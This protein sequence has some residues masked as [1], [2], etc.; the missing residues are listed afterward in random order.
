MDQQDAKKMLIEYGHWGSLGASIL[1]ILLTLVLG[2]DPKAKK[3][4]ADIEKAL[5][6]LQVAKDKTTVALEKLPDYLGKIKANWGSVGEAKKGPGQ[7]YFYQKADI[8]Y[9][10]AASPTHQWINKPGDL[11]LQVDR[12][13]LVLAWSKPSRVY[14]EGKEQEMT[15]IVG[16][17]LKREWGPANK[18]K[19]KIVDLKEDSTTEYEDT[20]VESKVEYSYQVRA[21]TE[22]I[23]A[24]GGEKIT[25][26]GKE[27]LV[28]EYTSEKKGA[29]LPVYKMQLLGAS[30]DMAVI[31]IFKWV[32]GDWRSVI[33]HIKKGG[34]IEGTAHFPELGK[35]EFTPGW[36]L[37]YL[38]PKH[39]I[40]RD[41]SIKVLR[42]DENGRP[43]KNDKGEYIYDIKME[44][45]K[46]T[47]A[48]IGYVDEKGKRQ[49]LTKEDRVDL[50]KIEKT[51]KKTDKKF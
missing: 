21:Y 17:H 44:P 42:L 35:V 1:L 11:T 23:K 39:I 51:D 19:H 32:K 10:Y 33:K 47:S 14:A 34:K 4:Q 49:K 13:K 38:N 20:N 12:E 30:E 45:T 41:R 28:S 8:K 29:I 46:V 3:T 48:L 50:E 18:R 9:K 40:T 6:D 24:K 16:Y 27:I 43:V 22:N 2:G 36:T 25:F 7:D 31:K 37:K 5:Q 26:E 15:E